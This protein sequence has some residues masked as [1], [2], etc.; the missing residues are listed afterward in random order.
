MAIGRSFRGA[1]GLRQ[2]PL[3]E[4]RRRAAAGLR[5]DRLKAFLARVKQRGKIQHQSDKPARVEEGKRRV[6]LESHKT[7][8]LFVVFVGCL[9]T[10]HKVSMSSGKRA[11]VAI[12]PSDWWGKASRAVHRF[13]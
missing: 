1:G 10:R 6:G 5:H 9:R 11:G 7:K 12:H 4:A 3:D 13:T 8:R 2:A